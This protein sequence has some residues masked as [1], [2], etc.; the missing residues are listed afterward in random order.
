VGIELERAPLIPSG[1]PYTV[2]G[3]ENTSLLVTN[4]LPKPCVDN[5]A[6]PLSPWEA[7]TRV[8]EQV[9]LAMLVKAAKNCPHGSQVFLDS[10]MAVAVT[11]TGKA[12]FR[13]ATIDDPARHF[14][15]P[16]HPSARGGDAQGRRVKGSAS[17]R[18]GSTTGGP[19][20]D[21]R[22]DQGPVHSL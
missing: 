5:A 2:K 18:Q 9:T 1:E 14:Q 20:T 3:I 16:D 13:E 19:L 22:D 7:A 6:M 4:V 21:R 15:G 10:E 12:K 11:A 8:H 17:P